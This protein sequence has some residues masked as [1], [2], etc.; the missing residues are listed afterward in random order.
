M[1]RGRA[2]FGSSVVCP[3]TT[4]GL[5]RLKKEKTDKSELLT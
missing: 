3:V 5:Y 2:L 4:R 1:T